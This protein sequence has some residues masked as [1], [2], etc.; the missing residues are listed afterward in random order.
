MT[1]SATPTADP[2]T[3]LAMVA[4]KSPSSGG[5]ADLEATV[6]APTSHALS[7]PSASFPSS[8]HLSAASRSTR[9]GGRA[10][11]FQ[12]VCR[13]PSL[14]TITEPSCGEASSPENQLS[15]GSP[16][17]PLSLSTAAGVPLPVIAS[18]PLCRLHAAQESKVFTSVSCPSSTCAK[19]P[20]RRTSGRATR[21]RPASTRAGTR[22]VPRRTAPSTRP[23]G[24][25][26]TT[27][28]AASGDPDLAIEVDSSPER[29]PVVETPS[30]VARGEAD[31][32]DAPLSSLR[33]PA[34]VSSSARAPGAAATPSSSATRTG[35]RPE[36]ATQASPGVVVG[37]SAAPSPNLTGGV[38]VQVNVQ[39]DPHTHIAP[40]MQARSTPPAP[41][42]QAPTLQAAA[43]R[44]PAVQ[45]AP[46]RPSGAPAVVTGTPTPGPMR[47]AVLPPNG[48]AGLP[49]IP[50]SAP[51]VEPRSASRAPGAGDSRGMD[52]RDDVPPSPGGYTG[53]SRGPDQ[54]PN[55]QSRQSLASEAVPD[56]AARRV[57]RR[58]GEPELT[59]GVPAT[60]RSELP[61]GF[62][63]WA[64][65]RIGLVYWDGDVDRLRTTRPIIALAIRL[66][67]TLGVD[68]ERADHLRTLLL[69][70]FCGHFQIPR[71]VFGD[72]VTVDDANEALFVN[73]I[74]VWLMDR[75]PST[76][77]DLPAGLWAA[78]IAHFA[79]PPGSEEPEPYRM[80]RFLSYFMRGTGRY[81]TQ[82]DLEIH[83]S[84]AGNTLQL[85]ATTDPAEIQR[86]IGLRV[87][88]YAEVPEA[89]T[90]CLPAP[91]FVLGVN[92]VLQHFGIVA[93]DPA[94]WGVPESQ[95][96]L[97]RSR[98]ERIAFVEHTRLLATAI[99]ADHYH[100]GRIVRH[101]GAVLRALEIFA[102]GNF[103]DI[104][105]HDPNVDINLQF[106][107][108][109]LREVNELGDGYLYQ[110]RDTLSG[111]HVTWAYYIDGAWVEAGP[112][113]G[114]YGGWPVEAHR[115]PDCP[116]RYVAMPGEPGHTPI[117]PETIRQ[118]L[119]VQELYYHFP[120]LRTPLRRLIGMG[121]RV[122]VR[123]VLE[124]LSSFVTPGGQ[125][126]T[127]RGGRGRRNSYGSRQ[128]HGDRR[129]RARDERPSGRTGY[130]DLLTDLRNANGNG[131][132]SARQGR[133]GGP[134][135]YNGGV[136]ETPS[137][138]MRPAQ[139][140]PPSG[141]DGGDGRGTI[142]DGR[143]P[144]PSRNRGG[145]I[146]SDMPDPFPEWR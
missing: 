41:A 77:P 116:T 2:T 7:T 69:L 117:P 122:A 36:V 84:V 140:L 10:S 55:V 56:D 74:G 68:S 119:D 134:S 62:T 26:D 121:R 114:V 136:V 42:G 98:F 100:T 58:D 107:I 8:P 126:G 73:N 54:V 23:L 63:R 49:P 71:F 115:N 93:M 17:L 92:R 104:H 118:M 105:I 27:N 96:D 59:V 12:P 3:P 91:G 131:N 29:D 76:S 5:S 9:S 40:V 87:T 72:R 43:V 108:T 33:P 88:D 79:L 18:P 130:M 65:R 101:P 13:R 82:D 57:R 39:Q 99:F 44:V 142:T 61:E 135:G 46:S 137:T 24:V 47:S 31:D 89:I 1:P 78:D 6:T 102:N 103:P 141:Q 45:A 138:P 20:P 70:R 15:C 128:D 106:Y 38:N 14:L 133:T 145:H 11:P 94:R 32:D 120:G 80:M 109:L 83:E 97:F 144:G 125:Q 66:I 75:R 111:E 143:R 64:R 127:P 19:M 123:N 139:A 21:A 35:D 53:P 25:A 16:I 30:E 112:R 95:C 67:N 86:V 52:I 50:R 48:V 81:I 51:V 146:I 4:D 110:R 129:Q 37:S 132:S 34:A 60:N 113:S 28:Q 124:R 22:I 90:L 85:L